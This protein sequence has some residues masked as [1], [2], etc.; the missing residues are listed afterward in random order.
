ME[1]LKP[2]DGL[3]LQHGNLS[4][5]WRRFRQ[6]FELYLAATG[7]ASKPPEVRSSLFLH[8]AGEDAVEVY[9]T[10]TFA[11]FGDELK[12]D[13]IM[14]KFEDYCNP[15]K[16][17]TYERYRFFTCAQGDMSI[18]QY[19]T[20]LKL[21]AKSCEFGL[22]EESLIRDRLVCGITSDALREK[23]LR[24]GTVELKDAIKTC[25]AAEIT[26]A[27]VKDMHVEDQGAQAQGG[28]HV[29]AVK[30]KQTRKKEKSKAKPNDVEKASTFNCKRCGTE[31]ASRQCPAFGKQCKNCNKLNHFAKMCRSKSVHA[32]DDDDDD[33]SQH[34]SLFVG[35]VHAETHSQTDEWTV[36]LQL[37][38][39]SVKFKLDTGAQANV[40]PYS[41]VQRQGKKHMI[42]PTNVKLSTYTGNKIA[43]KGKCNW[44][45]K[46]KK[47]SFV[48]EFIV[49]KSEAKPILGIQTCE[50]MGL[51]KRVMT[52][53]KD[54]EINILKEY[55][56]VFEGIGCLDGEHTIR[57]DNSV[58]PTVHPPRKV[59][60][61]LRE[62]LKAELNR[63]EKM[64]VITKIEE[65]TQW[66]NPIVI[67]E[68]S[69]GQLRI[70]L[71]PRD[72]NRAVMR[73][74]YQL[75]T[76]E[77]ITSRLSKAKHFTVLD[78]SSGFWQLKLDDDSSRLC[79][80]NTPFGRYRFLRLAFGINSAP[81][82]FHRTVRQ[83]F[84]GI[85]GVETYID[86]LLVWG[87][88][89]EQH[90]HRLRQVLERARAKNFK[91]NRGKC[92][93]GLDEIKY[94]GH[95][96]SKDGLKPD[97]SKIEAVK[98]M[99]TPECKKDVERFL[100]M[101]TYLAKFIPNMSQHT[102]P[103]RELTREDV[104]WQWG[105]EHQNA[106]DKLKIM[107]T[108]AP[109][110]RYYDVKLPVTLSVDASKSGLGAVLLQ[111]EKPVA[112]ASRALTE[113]EQRYAQIEKEMLAIVF[114]AERFHQY[115]YGREVN[116]ESDHK[117]LEVIMK[118]PLSSAPARIQRLLM[119]LQKYQVKVQYKPGAEMYIADT[120]SRAYLPET[121]S[122]DTDIEA[123]VH[124]VISNLPVSN[125]KL[126]E[127]KNETK[128]DTTLR[129]LTE[130]VLSGWP[131]TKQQAAKEI[132]AYWNY[133][134]EIS[135]VEGILFKG[136]RLIV[137]AAM[138][139][140][141]LQRVHESHLGIE[142]CRR[143]ARELLFWPG[144]SQ[145]IT[146]MVNSC[147]VCM[148]HQRQQSKEPLHPHSVPERPWQ[149]IGVDL[150]TFDQ[151]EY[152]L[153][154]D[155]YSKFIEVEWLKSDTRSATVI[156]HL[157][158]QFAR[159]GIPETVISDN[160]PQF[161]SREF[162]AFAKEWE[163]SHKTTSPHHAQSNGMAERGVQTV[164]QMLK[165]AKADG[166]DPYLSLLNLRSTPMDD[167]GASPAQLLMGR[168]LRTRLPATPQMLKPQTVPNTVLQTLQKRQQKQTEYFNQ[169]TRALQNLHTGENVRIWQQG[170]WNPA[171]VTGLSEHPRSYVVQTPDGQV[172]RRNRKFLM[173][174]RGKTNAPSDNDNPNK[175][176]K[177][178][179]CQNVKQQMASDNTP[180]K[181][182]IDIP[183]ETPRKASPTG[184]P[185]PPVKTTRTGRVI[186]KP[187]CLVEE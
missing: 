145:N 72:L 123:Q 153:L 10:F 127:F 143:R 121:D 25:L 157:K 63:M 172:Y 23:L 119:R 29:D 37:D 174:S 52:L 97:Q 128:K 61:T 104:A 96:F 168:R 88:T 70:C 20:E 66:V 67:V 39:K 15:R 44:K 58:T 129:T 141:M 134:D 94:L 7:G 148:T 73:E 163:F 17:I 5:N 124:M 64:K 185:S 45:V 112:Y 82:V 47:K 36:E 62:K 140:E 139:A 122:S 77:E 27:Q 159:H 151:Q 115:V 171:Q 152:L 186:S 149:K 1:G 13:K 95:I 60:V 35:A 55:A 164:K 26:K 150:F 86:D 43:V 81:E 19:V 65:P 142:S 110:L 79:T 83:L 120:L 179:D 34:A 59:P 106:F 84:E 56:D 146:D 54:G 11:E 161:S 117:P 24:L 138:R 90:D 182:D 166:K 100:G 165:K 133:R 102:E 136:E 8:I 169:R 57:I 69:N 107:L 118:K 33:A 38:R 144:L 156:T 162:Q 187:R 167:I 9:N 125:E 135:A 18:S 42:K 89:K 71:D 6:R 76:V 78:A 126:E 155:Y 91:L 116:V 99:A 46:Y 68:K 175:T 75:P 170:A 108:E 183:S 32:V 41:L 85:E 49:V 40:I 158:S 3:D 16:N 31:H 93:V 80:F 132:Q 181:R 137:P 105:G 98:K 87:E 131:E 147:N 154:V 28:K 2:P 173:Q 101:I 109:L 51:I 21:K 113:T 74:H 50:E 160:G 22:L 12:L 111:E 14:E 53:N 4:E 48:L 176:P 184:S 180:G 103:L 130:T 177:N 114:G 92:K 30:Y 178:M